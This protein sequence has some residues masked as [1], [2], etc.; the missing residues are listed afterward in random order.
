MKKNTSNRTKYLLN[1][2]KKVTDRLKTQKR[3][4]D[5][6]MIN[7][8]Y[9]DYKYFFELGYKKAMRDMDRK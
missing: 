7:E 9:I 6:D 2:I 8:R 4:E 1:H 5:I 3:Y